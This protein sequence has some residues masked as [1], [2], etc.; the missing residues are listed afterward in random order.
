MACSESSE[1][2]IWL[3]FTSTSD[4]ASPSLKKLNNKL[5]LLWSSSL[6]DVTNLY[7][8]EHKKRL[9]LK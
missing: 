4:E 6:R 7:I 5:K 8:T 1:S 2:H 3:M 9:F